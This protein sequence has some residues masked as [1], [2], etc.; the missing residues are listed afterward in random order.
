V[1]HISTLVAGYS[2]I[3]SPVQVFAQRFTVS[4]SGVID[5]EVVEIV[6][7]KS[8]YLF[9]ELPRMV[10][11]ITQIDIISTTSQSIAVLLRYTGNIDIRQ[12]GKN[13]I[14]SDVSI[15]GGSFDHNLILFNGINLSDPQT[16]HFSL[17]LPVESEALS[18]VEILNGPAARAHGAN[19][20]LGA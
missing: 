8:P 6:G 14:Q 12:R 13:S 15:R 9:E 11:V 2:L 7:Q 3:V 18:R 17:N 4:V 19:A 10:S 16:G 5:H 20:F 1:I